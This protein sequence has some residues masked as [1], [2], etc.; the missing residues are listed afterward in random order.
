[1]SPIARTLLLWGAFFLVGIFVYGPAV[2]GEFLSDDFHYVATN[3]YVHTPSVS[4]LIAIWNPQSEVTILVENYAP[5]HL[6]LHSLEWQFFGS[7]VQGYHVVNIGLHALAAAMLVCVY[8]RSGIGLWAAAAGA[9]LFF[10]HP[11]NV[12]SVAWISQIKSASALVLSLGALLLHPRRPAWALALF[13]LALLAKPFAAFALIVVAL[14]AWIRTEQDPGVGEASGAAA[15]WRWLLGWLAV[16]LLY[17]TVESSAFSES[18]AMTPPLYA[19]GWVRVLMIFSVALRYSWM[20]LSG[21]GLSTFHEPLPVS[22]LADP[23]LIGGVLVVVLLGIWAGV[24]LVKRREE[25]AYLIWAAVSFAPL[26][27]VIPLPYPMADRYLYFILPG[28][29]GAFLL[30]GAR[31]TKRLADGWALDGETRKRVRLIALVV[32]GLVLIHAGQLTHD[33]ARV[34]VSPESLM[35]DAERNY[36][37]GVAASTRKA[38]RAAQEGRFD[39]AVQY[40]KVARV[41]GYNRVDNLLQDP[42]FGPMQN[43]PDFVAIKHEMADDWIDRLSQKEEISHYTA[44]ALAQAYIV[45]DRYAEAAAVLEEAAGR[46]GPIGDALWQDAQN[47]RSEIAFRNRL[48]AAAESRKP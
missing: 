8:R 30:G 11:A 40:L 15:H 48:K 18:A 9:S 47:V 28:L 14:F 5:V 24:S 33:R 29:I 35:S 21:R 16:V 44:R 31:W 20:S 43:Y 32:L 22:G 26:S 6:M 41:R 25:A 2:Q 17:A 19:D 27:G 3:E 1:M 36:P 38:T 34:F 42:S 4:N 46:P 10:L 37:E 23:F 45:K 13:A 39:D 7:S 12:E